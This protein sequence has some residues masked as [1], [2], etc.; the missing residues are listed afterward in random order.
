MA[1]LTF[2][3]VMV[4]FGLSIKI[5]IESLA[6]DLYDQNR[7]SLTEYNYIRSSEYFWNR[8]KYIINHL[9]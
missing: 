4:M 3:A 7:I 2:V 8:I 6:I 9:W 5:G 1:I